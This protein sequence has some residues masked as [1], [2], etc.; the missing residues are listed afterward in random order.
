MSYMIKVL[1]QLPDGTY[2]RLPIAK[3][4]DRGIEVA[5]EPTKKEAKYWAEFVLPARLDFTEKL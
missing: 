1:V 5:T 3:Q 4:T 2:M